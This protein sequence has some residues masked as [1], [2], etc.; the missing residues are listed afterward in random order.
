MSS[1]VGNKVDVA[2]GGKVLWKLLLSY[3][4]EH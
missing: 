1:E 3:N 2:E 4:D